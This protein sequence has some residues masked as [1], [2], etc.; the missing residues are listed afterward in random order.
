MKT[1]LA[2]DGVEVTEKVL[3]GHATREGGASASNSVAVQLS[4]WDF[5]TSGAA[6]Q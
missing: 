3:V 5:G 1:N 2:T 4:F 6:L